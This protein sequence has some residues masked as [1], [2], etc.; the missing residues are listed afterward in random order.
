MKGLCQAAFGAYHN[1]FF[2]PGDRG[3]WCKQHSCM[4]HADGTYSDFRNS[5][6]WLTNLVSVLWRVARH[7]VSLVV[8]CALFAA[9]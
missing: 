4:P 6:R 8:F 1:A 5:E 2:L 3:S 7:G 9:S